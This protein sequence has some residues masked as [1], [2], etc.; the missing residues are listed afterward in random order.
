[1]GLFKNEEEEKKLNIGDKVRVKNKEQQ[2]IITGIEE[3]MYTVLINEI[4]MMEQFE[5]EELE[6]YW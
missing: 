6:K 2:G 1:M 4:M 5:A 3:N